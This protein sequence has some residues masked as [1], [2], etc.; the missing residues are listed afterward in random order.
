[1]GFWVE[2][3]NKKTSR[4]KVRRFDTALLAMGKRVGLSF[5]EINELSVQDLLD[6]V[7]DYAGA[8]DEDEG[9]RMATQEDIDRFYSGL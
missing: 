5:A 7:G 9:P 1:M 2:V 6:F 8:G 3:E 4:Q